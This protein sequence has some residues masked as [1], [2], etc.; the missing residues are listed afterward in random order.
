MFF[1]ILGVI[2]ILEIVNN[3]ITLTKGDTAILNLTIYFPNME[4]QYELMDG[5]IVTFSLTNK[6]ECFGESKVVIKKDFE[7][8]EIQ[9]NPIDTKY[10]SCGKYEYDVQLTFKNGDVNTIIGPELFYLTTE[11]TPSNINRNYNGDYTPSNG[12]NRDDGQLIGILNTGIKKVVTTNTN[13]EDLQDVELNNPQEGD[14]L[15]FFDNKWINSDVEKVLN[16]HTLVLDGGYIN[17]LF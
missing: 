1:C 8:N 10:L 6:T 16:Y 4:E 13:L 7:Q 9:L 5:D 12:I 11:I 17:D 15:S 14:L 2:K 3:Q